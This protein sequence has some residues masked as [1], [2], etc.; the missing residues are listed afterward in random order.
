VDIIQQCWIYNPEN[1][2]TI[3]DVVLRLRKAVDDNRRLQN[4]AIHL[5][6]N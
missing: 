3:G 5:K 4:Q 2:I 1:R 6:L